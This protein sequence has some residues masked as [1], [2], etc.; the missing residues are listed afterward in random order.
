VGGVPLTQ[1]TVADDLTIRVLLDDG[2]MLLVLAGELDTFGAA[3]LAPWLSGA[4]VIDMAAVTFI[5]SR[6]LRVLG[7][8]LRAGA[9]IVIRDPSTVVRRALDVA[10]LNELLE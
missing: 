1:T 5:D 6:G 3:Q 4:V 8:A 10:H 2:R 9:H 7:R